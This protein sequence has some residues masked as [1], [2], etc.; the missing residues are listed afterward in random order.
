MAPAVRRSVP[1]KEN[2]ASMSSMTTR[3]LLASTALLAA[4][5]A[6]AQFRFEPAP[7][8]TSILPGATAERAQPDNA[9]TRR[10]PDPIGQ[11]V[12]TWQQLD[13]SDSYPFSSYATFLLAHRGF[14]NERAMRVRAERALA[15]GG[16]DPRLVVAY[17]DAFPPITGTGEA[18]RAVA[19]MNTGQ[20]AAAES[21]A[22]RAWISGALTPEDEV[23]VLQVAPAALTPQVQ[24]ARLDRLLWTG[25]TSKALISLN[26]ASAAKA[27][28]FA[29]RLSLQQNDPNAGALID[30]APPAWRSDP[31]FLRDAAEWMR[32]NGRSYDARQL[33][34]QRADFAAPPT[35]AEDWMETA[36]ALGR[37]AETDG[38]YQQ[39]Y[40]IARRLDDLYPPG[41]DV[42]ELSYGDRDEYTNLAWLGGR[43]ALRRIGRPADAAVLFDRY[44][45]AA[46]SGQTRSKGFYWAGVAAKGAGDAAGARDFWRKAAVY[47][48]SFYGLL[49]M[50]ELG[51]VAPP[52][53]VNDPLTPQDA[54]VRQA[55]AL[56]Q[57]I[58]YLGTSG[59]WETQGK[60]LRA[61]AEG[62][63]TPADFAY[64]HRLSREIGRPDLSVMLARNAL[65]EE[66]PG[67]LRAGFPHVDA[68]GDHRSLQSL[69]NGIT[70]QESQF[71]PRARSRVGATGLMQLMP[72]TAREQAGKIGIGYDTGSLTQPAYNVQLGTSYFDRLLTRFGGSY[73]LA[74]AAYNA[75]GGNVNKWLA[76]N[77]DPRTGQIDI[78]DWIEAIPF[79]ETRGYVQRVL[80][81][82]TVYDL[83]DPPNA[84][85]RGPRPLSGYLARR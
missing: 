41:T 50:E 71:D 4:S 48:T 33:F 6:A 13:Q 24:D 49:A 7:P 84:T 64:G 34:A 14:P 46:K 70:R 25:Q 76:Q 77:G 18:R 36:V 58:R 62:A 60:F 43:V 15:F 52:P 51:T 75:G 55:A 8:P 57:A 23:A 69:V 30:T 81:N 65:G 45:R 9:L 29:A 54:A 85:M 74:V 11:A 32:R 27:P 44:G 79:S 31:G 82:A 56:P 42:S 80:E 63:Q 83:L 3:I 2:T 21:A 38:N 73:P 40:D 35:D 47:R 10:S 78:L 59:D 1:D 5:P 37:G 68:P 20:R 17:F 22:A 53:P 28:L 66:L 19:L 39:A 61:Y 12:A 72:A 16:D 26:Q 67:Q